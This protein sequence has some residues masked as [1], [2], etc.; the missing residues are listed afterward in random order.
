VK[1]FIIIIIN[2][3]YCTSVTFTMSIKKIENVLPPFS[4][5]RVVALISKYTIGGGKLSVNN[6][7][8]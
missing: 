4:S 1:Q 7:M 3:A 5:Y 8:N 2:I 6:F